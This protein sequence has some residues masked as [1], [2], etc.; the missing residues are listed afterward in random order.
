M[1]SAY[2][3]TLPETGNRMKLRTR[4]GHVPGASNTQARI[5]FTA[6]GEEKRHVI[7][8]LRWSLDDDPASAVDITVSDG[9]NTETFQVTTGGPGF[10][11]MDFHGIINGAVTITI[12][13]TAS[14][15]GTLAADGYIELIPGAA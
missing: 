11:L 2:Y 6:P 12:P 4:A 9:T 8:V 7:K 5:T 15:T 14:I 13:A 10:L 1:A 3:L